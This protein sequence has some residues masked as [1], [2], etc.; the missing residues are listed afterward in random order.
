MNDQAITPAPE[1]PAQPH[2]EAVAALRQQHEASRLRLQ[3]ATERLRAAL[4]EMQSAT[5]ENLRLQ[6][7][8][9]FRTDDQARQRIIEK[10]AACE[11]HWSGGPASAGNIAETIARE[12]ALAMLA[13]RFDPSGGFD[14][15]RATARACFTAPPPAAVPAPAAAPA[16]APAPAQVQGLPP[17]DSPIRIEY[18]ED[19]GGGPYVRVYLPTGRVALV[20]A[21]SIDEPEQSCVELLPS[22]QA[23]EDGD[24]G[25]NV[26][27]W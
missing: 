11:A 10:A 12:Q 16:A 1:T 4:D 9:P 18:D 6:A 25:Q 21:R 2:P 23:L 5:G 7:S 27:I 8:D 26:H 3:A 13:D 24:Y 14:A 22:V 20:W 17:E 19:R 15:A